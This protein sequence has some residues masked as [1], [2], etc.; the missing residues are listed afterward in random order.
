MVLGGIRKETTA[1]QVSNEVLLERAGSAEQTACHNRRCPV[2][3][4]GFVLWRIERSETSLAI[5]F[6]NAGEMIRDSSLRPE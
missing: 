1:L 4:G 2:R 3:H 5:V 6:R